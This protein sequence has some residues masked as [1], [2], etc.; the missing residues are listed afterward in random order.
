[1]TTTS[2]TSGRKENARVL[3]RFDE[4]KFYHEYAQPFLNRVT[5]YW[6]DRYEAVMKMRIVAQRHRNQE[7]EVKILN[8]KMDEIEKPSPV[9]ARGPVLDS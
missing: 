2:Q 1:M 3:S 9:R 5:H 4:F 6:L 7:L 8:A